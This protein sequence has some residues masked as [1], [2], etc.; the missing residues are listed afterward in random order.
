MNFSTKYTVRTDMA[1][2]ILEGLYGKKG[3][4]DDGITFKSN[5]YGKIHSET[6]IVSH[7][8]LWGDCVKYKGEYTTVSVDDVKNMSREDFEE[9]AMV[10]SDVIKN[11]LPDNKGLCLAVCLGNRNL[12]ADAV[13]PLCSEKIIVSRHIKKHSEKLYEAM[14]LGEC[15]CVTPGVL[16]ETGME[17]AELIK[18]AVEMLKPSCIIA[19]DAL[20]SRRL[21]RLVKTVQIS[22]TGISPG[23][24]VN[25]TRNEISEKTLGVPV[26]SVGVPTVVEASTV[27]M[28]VLAE[29]SGFDNE[30]MGEIERTL[31]ENPTG[32]F[33]TPKDADVYVRNMAKLIAFSV[34]KA[35]HTDM[36]FSEMEELLS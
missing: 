20:A 27:C 28:D 14:G 26:I 25:N 6:M 34:N 13:G 5:D 9:S 10:I 36:S 19:I 23:S 15:A 12:V 2:E 18:G 3:K 35:L 11:M 1:D 21:S 8:V 22:N 29:K 31:N 4:K 24:G 32:F 7:D 16:G 30:K 33:V 17:A